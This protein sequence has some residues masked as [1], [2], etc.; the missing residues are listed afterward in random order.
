MQKQ[1][2]VRSGSRYRPAKS[3]E[4]LDAAAF[5]EARKAEIEGV[6]LDGPKDGA[7]HLIPQCRHLPFEVL[8]VAFLT[9]GLRII[10]VERMFRGTIDSSPIHIREIAREVIERNA[11]AIIVAHNHPSGSSEPSPADLRTTKILVAAMALIETQ[12]LDHVIVSATDY[13]SF[14]QRGMM[15]EVR[16]L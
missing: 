2:F 7:E 8:T 15:P 9:P 3:G 12:V 11:S 13:F 1:L 6:Q 4:I 5:A 14:A 16:G 10:G